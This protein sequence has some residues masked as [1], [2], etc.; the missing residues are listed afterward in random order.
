MLKTSIFAS[1][2]M[3]SAFCACR[4]KTVVVKKLV[5][6]GISL[7]GFSAQ[8]KVSDGGNTVPTALIFNGKLQSIESRM[9][10]YDIPG[11]SIALIQNRQI[12]WVANFGWKDIATQQE[13]TSDTL[14]QVASISKP[15]TAVAALKL[16]EEGKLN[17][18]TP[19]NEYLQSWQIPKN[20]HNAASPVLVKQLLN[21]TA[22]LTVSGFAGYEVGKPIPS[23]TEVLE[24]ASLFGRLL[25]QNNA[26]SPSVEVAKTP[27]TDFAYSGG[28]YS[29]LQQL[30]VDKEHTDFTHLM[31]Q[32]VLSPLGMQQ[33]TFQQP[34][35]NVRA[36]F[37]AT[38]Y[39]ENNKPVAG[40]YHVY[41]EQAAAGLWTTAS[42]LAK[43][44]ID[45][46]NALHDDSGVV[47][48]QAS[49][50]T[51]TSPTINQAV[52]LGVFLMGANIDG[53]G[54]FMH[55][56]WNKGFSSTMLAHKSEG[57][58]VIILTN[59][60]KPNF[61]KELVIGLMLEYGWLITS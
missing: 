9:R 14:F 19:A 41:P 7:I 55:D 2:F 15:V 49:A 53:Q 47:L 27:G 56:G 50:K 37:V 42:D 1:Q 30:L 5:I 16:V 28:G 58:G 13:V 31:Q 51:M 44:A 21:H 25:G 22:G 10:D 23:I 33:S 12:S 17:L 36:D 45:I 60:N 11:V 57:Y 35:D 43:F 61:N 32:K 8:A 24:G 40:H 39:M 38:G 52:G 6:V 3:E 18:N 26:N 34:I 48:S 46:Q 29:V 59:A 20:E 54:Y 4:F